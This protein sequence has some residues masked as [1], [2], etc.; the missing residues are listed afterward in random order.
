MMLFIFFTVMTDAY[1]SAWGLLVSPSV[2]Q[3][4][5]SYPRRAYR[6]AA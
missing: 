3:S 5:F 4:H 1:F 2:T 6:A